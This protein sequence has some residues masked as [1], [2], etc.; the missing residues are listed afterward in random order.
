MPATNSVYF[1]RQDYASFWRRLLID[2]IDCLAAAVICAIATIAL[3]AWAS[4][5]VI[6]LTWVA[7]A[8]CY[9]VLLKWSRI[10]TLGYR[11]GGVKIVGPGGQP[12]GLGALTLRLA[13]MSL[14]PLNNLID[15]AFLSGDPHRQAL[16]DKLAQTYVVKRQAEPV[17]TGRQ[18]R[19]YYEICGYNF[20][21][22]EI[23]EQ[24]AAPAGPPP[25]PRPATPARP[26][27]PD[28]G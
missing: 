25:S 8:F 19:K 15:L 13:F 22:R 14:G 28:A 4:V 23:E 3:W 6:L 12:A 1:R 18:V 10:G 11:A 21:F 16:R 17:G 27:V 9:F 24:P 2:V 20:I 5:D 7:V 26:G